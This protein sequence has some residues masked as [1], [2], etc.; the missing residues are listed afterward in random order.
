MI[1]VS[2]IVKNEE[3]CLAKCLESV[4]GADEIVIIDTG[5]TDK[6]IEIAKKYTDKVFEGKEFMWRDDFAYHRNQ[7]LERC[8]GE[9]ILIIDADETLEEGG[10]EKIRALLPDIKKNCVYTKVISTSG[11]MNHGIRLFRSGKGIHWQEPAHNVLSERD[12]DYLDVTITYGYS[13]AHNLDPDRTLRIL[14]K[15]VKDKPTPRRLYYLAREYWYR[16]DYGKA[17]QM[18]D[19]YLRVAHWP[20]EMADAHLMKAR[21]LWHRQKGQDARRACMEAIFINPDFKEALSFMAEM[22][23]EPMKTAWSKYAETA[24]NKNVLFIRQ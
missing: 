24:T 3:S 2:M 19:R 15:A 21:C 5:S 22:H 8:T 6:T 9:W 13:A 7:S 16:K 14:S 4:R 20:P 23:Y 10:I 12:G 11:D 17:C 18:Y 1:S